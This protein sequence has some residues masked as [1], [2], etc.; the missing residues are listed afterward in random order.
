MVRKAVELLSTHTISPV[1]NQNLQPQ[2]VKTAIVGSNY[3]MCLHLF[4]DAIRRRIF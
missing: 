1:I 2:S 3:E 4:G